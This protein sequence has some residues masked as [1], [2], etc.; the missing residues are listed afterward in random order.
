MPVPDALTS[1]LEAYYRLLATWNEKINLTALNVR[2]A[3]DDS[4]DRLLVEPLVAARHIAPTNGRLIDVGSGGGSPAIPIKLALPDVTLLMVES[5][6]RKSV[7]LREAVR[8]LE[9]SATNVATS[10]FEELLA[11]PDLHEACDVVTLRAVLLEKMTIAANLAL[12]LTVAIDPMSPATRAEVEALA[13]VVGLPPARL[14]QEAASLSAAER[15]RVHL[16]RALAPGPRLLLLEHP[17]TALNSAATSA[18]L[19]ATLRRAADA[20]G[21]GWILITEDRALARAAGAPR[22]KLDAATGRLRAERFWE[23][24]R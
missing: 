19:G 7:F 11:R 4:F 13:A 17:T 14:D 6:T 3:S 9:L 16:A 15:V 12:P 2:D 1:Q 24:W 21:L 8:A 10:R 23:R 22:F 5:K 18:D 20:R